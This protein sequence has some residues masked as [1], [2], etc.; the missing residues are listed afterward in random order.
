MIRLLKN[1]K[2]LKI[3][4]YPIILLLTCVLY[5]C[6]SPEEKWLTDYKAVKC[7]SV[8]LSEKIEEEI[9]KDL[10]DT[11]T[12]KETLEK[13]LKQLT[14][15]DEKKINGFNDA[16]KKS[17]EDFNK[18]I[19]DAKKE[20]EKAKNKEE[21]KN[22]KK[23]VETLEFQKSEA[24][25]DIGQK[26]FVAKNEMNKKAAVKQIKEDI[27]SKDKFIK[28]KTED[29]KSKYKGEIKRLQNKILELNKEKPKK[30][31]EEAFK[32]QIEAIDKAPCK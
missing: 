2:S 22:L 4:L 13:D 28:E 16:L 20:L 11:I 25:K 7:D 18:K 10:K 15:A 17:D 1:I 26:I 27:K 19:A 14:S 21:E 30:L 31:E 12:A 6:T 23:K 32:K 9:K 24:G 8:K 3:F 5:A 29:K